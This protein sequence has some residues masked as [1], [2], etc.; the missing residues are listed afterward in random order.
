MTS[1]PVIQRRDGWST[2]PSLAARG[3]ADLDRLIDKYLDAQAEGPT[4]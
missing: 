1:R 3:S 2:Q 4:T